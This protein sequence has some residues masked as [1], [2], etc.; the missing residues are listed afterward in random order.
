[1]FYKVA[2]WLYWPPAK[3]VK[4][5]TKCEIHPLNTADQGNDLWLVPMI[6]GPSSSTKLQWPQRDKFP[7]D[8]HNHKKGNA[9]LSLSTILFYCH[10]KNTTS[11]LMTAPEH[12]ARPGTPKTNE[13]STM[14]MID[15]NPGGSY[16]DLPIAVFSPQHY[17]MITRLVIQA[18]G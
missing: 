4:F 8:S 15:F 6:Y 9:F 13:I 7:H 2:K 10:C 18:F 5:T 11:S 17:I 1:M 14:E 12:P 3:N 16:I